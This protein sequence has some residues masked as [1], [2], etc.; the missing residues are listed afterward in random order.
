MITRLV[1]TKTFPGLDE[2]TTNGNEIEDAALSGVVKTRSARGILPLLRN[3]EAA[4]KAE[5]NG[6][7]Q[8]HGLA[9]LPERMPALGL[10]AYHEGQ[11]LAA[12]F[13]FMSNCGCGM[14]MIQFLM[15]NP[16]APWGAAP[17]ALDAVLVGLTAALKELDY[18]L[19]MNVTREASLARLMRRHGFE[20]GDTGMTHYLK[21]L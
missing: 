8:S 2:P 14:A 20:Q 12:G 21:T 9:P 3:V 5:L 10:M 6:W 1:E 18:S 19:V 17:V 13:A 16:L 7:W 15:V 4:D 11:N